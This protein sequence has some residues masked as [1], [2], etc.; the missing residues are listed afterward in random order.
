MPLK[1]GG[2]ALTERDDRHYFR[3]L[4]YDAIIE[5]VSDHAASPPGKER[6]AS[7]RPSYDPEEVRRWLAATLEGLD[8]LRC[9]DGVSM[10][11][12]RDISP[13]RRRARNAGALEGR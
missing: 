10:S 9:T 4:E 13:S 7:L 1:K 8:I 3:L 6:A 11:V 5:R 2:E 12:V